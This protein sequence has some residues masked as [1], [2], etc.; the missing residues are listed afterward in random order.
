MRSHDFVIPRRA[1]VACVLSLACAVSMAEAQA[2]TFTAAAAISGSAAAGARVTVVVQR[3]TSDGTRKMLIE[4]LTKGATPAARALLAK[5]P[6]VGTVQIGDRRTVLKY[7]YARETTAGRQITAVTAEPIALAGAGSPAAGF[8]LG[9]VLLDVDGSG[10]GR[11]DLVP[12]T[13]I[14]VNDDGAFETEDYN[15]VVLHL[16]NVVATGRK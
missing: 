10:T 7:V 3:Y 12:A 1:G 6:D 14:R 5:E 9:L 13:K 15:G 4:A 2:E 16:S 11:G 8:D